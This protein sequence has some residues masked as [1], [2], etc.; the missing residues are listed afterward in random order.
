MKRKII[1]LGET[2]YDI[3]FKN[4][5]PVDAKVGGSQLNT[6]ISLGR[7]GHKVIF[8]SAFGNDRLGDN[9]L[10]F[11]AENGVE[12]SNIS[13]YEGNSRLAIAFLDEKNNAD[14]SF[15]KSTGNATLQYPEIGQGDIVLFGSS[16]ALGDD[17]RED[18][19]CFLS[20]AKKAGGIIIYDPNFRKSNLSRLDELMPVM[21]ENMRYSTILK[22][23]DEDFLN[24]FNVTSPPE[25]WDRLKKYSCSCMLYTAGANGV[26]VQPSGIGYFNVPAIKPVSTIGAGDSFTAGLIHGL[27]TC[28]I[29]AR[30]VANIPGHTW[31]ELV[32]MANAFAQHVCMGY[33]N[34]ISMDF[35]NK[36]RNKKKCP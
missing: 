5:K 28:Q 17:K 20:K 11:I 19:T 15:Y 26:S 23:S 34:Y 33:D 36:I 1:I 31:E 32:S 14:Y 6:A 27:I 8:V 13:R 2:T 35:A 16:F 18:L 12:T 29:H 10:D 25:V 9:S 3:I 7:L 4:N 22:G 30:E 24:I 21:E